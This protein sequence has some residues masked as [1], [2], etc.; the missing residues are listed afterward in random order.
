MYILKRDGKE[1]IRKDTYNECLEYLQGASPF[2]WDY[3]FKYNG[4]SINETNTEIE[5]G[6]YDSEC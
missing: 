1:L 5:R 2:S 6:R 4:Y 3:N